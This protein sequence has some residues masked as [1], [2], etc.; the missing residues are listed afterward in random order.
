MISLSGAKKADIDDADA[1]L[2]SDC[3]YN[4]LSGLACSTRKAGTYIIMCFLDQPQH[5]LFQHLRPP[6]NLQDDFD[7]S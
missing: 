6:V 5:D 4:I 2:Y 1:D 3:D 7:P